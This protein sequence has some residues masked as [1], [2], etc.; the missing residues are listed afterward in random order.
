MENN[1]LKEMN[2]ELR[3]ILTKSDEPHPT[4]KKKKESSSRNSKKRRRKKER[5]KRFS[6]VAI[7]LIVLVVLIGAIVAAG[8]LLSY[9]GKKS[10]LEHKEIEGVEITAPEEVVVED[11]GFKVQHNGKTYVRNEDVISIMLLGIDRPDFEEEGLVTGEN[12]QADTVLVAALDTVTGKL[13]LLNISRDS[14]VDVDVYNTK[15]E[16]VE[17]KEMQLC[18]AYAYGDGR[19]GSCLNMMK[20]VS[21][22]LFGMP[23][24]A[25]AAINLSA[26]SVLNDAVGGVE[27]TVLE[28]L[29]SK[30]PA[31]VKGAQVV[32]KGQQA[33]TYVRSRESG[34]DAPVDA[35]NARM[36]RQKQYLTNL[37]NT[38]I[39]QL[40]KD[41]SV[42]LS[43]YQTVKDYMVT[44]IDASRSLYL[45]SLA[46]KGNFNSQDI[47]TVPGTV[48]M[49]EQYA[50]YH[51]DD[52]AL[53]DIILD[54]YYNE[55]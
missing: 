51:V 28:D 32:L 35:N 9:S 7:L 48:T 12:G 31:L 54:V 43:L 44:D 24:D 46:V 4:V 11:E 16:F 26:I 33:M 2:E 50:E 14:M 23:I 36:A 53:Y 39:K 30:D 1:E 3:Q 15:N 13:T 19:E 49:G 40:R 10:L 52:Q 47:R 25:Y 20:S 45:A 5:K 34:D 18:L 8:F 37:I 38:T 22:L 55:I 21:R 42:T 17:S 29:T 6:P 27:V 41:L